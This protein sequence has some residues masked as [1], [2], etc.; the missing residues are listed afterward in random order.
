MPGGA[1]AAA[2]PTND[3]NTQPKQI[4]HAI[5]P[6]HESTRAQKPQNINDQISIV[7]IHSGELHAKLPRS[8][9]DSAP[10]HDQAPL[11]WRAPEGP[12]GLAAVPVGGGRAW[13]DNEPTPN[14]TS[15]HQAPLVW[16]VPE[17]PEGQGGLRDRP[18]RAKLACGDLAGGRARRRPERPWGHAAKPRSN[19]RERVGRLPAPHPSSTPGLSTAVN[20]PQSINQHS[21]RRQCLRGANLRGPAAGQPGGD[22]RGHD[23]DDAHADQ[24]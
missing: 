2:V 18:L 5:P 19:T 4:S 1:G 15:A 24:L 16:R 22:E 8:S 23:G 12:E 11:V 7:E 3:S 17:G 9:Q 14:H 20:Q 6:R 21:L 10:C 13:P